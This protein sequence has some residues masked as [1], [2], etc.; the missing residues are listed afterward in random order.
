MPTDRATPTAITDAVTLNNGVRMPRLGLGTFKAREGDEVRQAVRWALE[1]GY[2][3]IDTAAI[4]HNEAGVGEGL[5]ESG[6]PRDEV[7]ITTKLWNDDQ[8]YDSALRAFDHSARRVG[9]DTIDLY[10]IHWPGPASGESWR[11][12]EKLHAEG[13]ARA[14]GVSNF[15]A[16]HLE[17]LLKRASVVP[18][19]N[20][21]EFHPLLQQPRAVAF[22]REHGIVVEAW[23]P[24]LK[25]RVGELPEVAALAKRI[26]RTPAQVVLRWQLQRGIVTIPKSVRR[27]RLVE[28]AALFDFELADGDV[29]TLD[30]LDRHERTG[31]DPDTFGF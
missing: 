13:R 29:A 16:H 6:V 10:L 28:N 18:A 21:I 4:Y 15:L 14:I 17:D 22:C 5:R 20:Q 27:E 30:G 19:V 26:G 12:L 1:L 7:F 23:S 24:L 2:R 8:G 31:P 9:V 11:A 3:H 25:G